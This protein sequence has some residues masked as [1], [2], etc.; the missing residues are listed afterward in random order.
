[1]SKHIWP[2]KALKGGKNAVTLFEIRY[3][4]QDGY[5]YG[6]TG[7]CPIDIR[8]I[9]IPYSVDAILTPGSTG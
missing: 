1:M 9:P 6:Y 3:V 5:A 8:E 7:L 2:L 4:P